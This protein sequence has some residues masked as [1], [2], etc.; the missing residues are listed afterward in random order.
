M[1]DSRKG[2]GRGDR[3]PTL[4]AWESVGNVRGMNVKEKG[5]LFPFLCTLPCFAPEPISYPESPSSLASGWS[6]GKTLV[7]LKKMKSQ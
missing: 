4:G 7:K 1:A 5:V 3:T 6:P 2:K